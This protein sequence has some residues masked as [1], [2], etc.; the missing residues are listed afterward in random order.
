MSKKIIL[1]DEFYTDA[2]PEVDEAFARSKRISADFLPSPEELAKA[3]IKK[4]V[5]I[6]LDSA[7]VDFF[8]EIAKE[9]GTPYQTLINSLL[10]EYV[11][12]YRMAG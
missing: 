7:S 9:N 8:K 4:T 11:S 3:A 5:T 6:R 10:R 12:H 1:D 2:P